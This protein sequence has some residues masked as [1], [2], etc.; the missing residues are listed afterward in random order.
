MEL[1]EFMRLP[2]KIIPQEIIDKYKLEDIAT[3]GWVYT[4]IVKG[5]YGLPQ[6]GKIANDLLKKKIRG[7]RTTPGLWRHVWR[8]TTFTL[9]VDEFGVKFD[10]NANAN[11]LAKTLERHYDVIVDSKG[12]L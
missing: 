12:E 3:N 1:P 5:I 8:S 7:F 10:G 4:K 9:V 6:A 11:H 2:M